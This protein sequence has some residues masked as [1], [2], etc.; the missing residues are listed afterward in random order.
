ML[1]QA[2]KAQHKQ[3]VSIVGFGV[4]APSGCGRQAHIQKDKLIQKTSPHSK[5]QAHTKNQLIPQTSL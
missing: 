2:P 5:R 4:K 3:C 1:F